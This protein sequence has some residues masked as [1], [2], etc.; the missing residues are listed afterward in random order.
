MIYPEKLQVGDTIGVTAPSSGVTGVIA[1]KFDNA[2][3]QLEN[4]GYNIK[5]TA[6]V[7]KQKKLTSATAQKRAEE[8][9]SL[10]FDPEVKAIIPPWGGELLM[11]M[12][13]YI[14][15]E[16]MKQHT[17][18]WIMGFSDTSTL[19]FSLTIKLN[20]AT[21]HGPNLL[22]FGSNPIHPSVT[23]ALEYLNKTEGDNFT[24]KS[25]DYYQKEWLEVTE[26]T[27]PPYNLTEEVNWK[28]LGGNERKKI[29]GRLLG[30]NLDVICKLI[31]TPYA[32]VEK[33]INQFEKGFIWY[34]ESCEMDSADL[35]RTFW[36]MKMNNWFDNCN[37]ILFGRPE[38]YNDVA[39]FRLIDALN[40]SFA[41]E[42][43]P[44]FYNLDI[45][46]L[47]PQLTLINGVS[48]EVIVKNGEGK[49]KQHLN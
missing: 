1:N 18:K 45:G 22:D 26:D 9:L 27:F 42:K 23:A 43:F 29:K 31:G 21:A 41:G 7:R 16:K 38:G 28:I 20:M 47:P 6:S 15:Y 49:V 17:P 36:Q 3:K 48:A 5:E 12:L 8:F 33:F 30:G 46:H 4:M 10:Y 44:V 19:L 39:D 14:D 25:M 24:Q 37:G 2:I 11:E 13:P 40:Y 35:Y 32:P 34:F